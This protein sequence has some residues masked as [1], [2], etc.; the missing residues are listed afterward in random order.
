MTF[1]D[2]LVMLTASPHGFRIPHDHSKRQWE[3]DQLR[4]NYLTWKRG[5]LVTNWKS[6]CQRARPLAA[7]L[8]ALA[9]TALQTKSPHTSLVWPY[10]LSH[11]S[12]VTSPPSPFW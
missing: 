7:T 6:G 10:A 11:G 8:W 5:Q 1:F 3:S 2:A 12:Y 4:L 9:R